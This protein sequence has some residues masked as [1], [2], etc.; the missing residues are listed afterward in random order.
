MCG[1]QRDDGEFLEEPNERLH[2]CE[3][4]DNC[5]TVVLENG[6]FT[7]DHGT[8]NFTPPETE[9]WKNHALKV[10]S[11]GSFLFLNPSIFRLL[12]SHGRSS[13]TAPPSTVTSTMGGRSEPAS[14][15]AK[16]GL[17][18][19]TSRRGWTNILTQSLLIIIGRVRS[20]AAVQS[21]AISQFKV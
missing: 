16:K 13:I 2:E 8:F 9:S 21:T 4:E 6:H 17:W 15:C 20:G 14:A 12:S 11:F 7:I 5:F 18:T 19:K 1:V 3:E 10:K